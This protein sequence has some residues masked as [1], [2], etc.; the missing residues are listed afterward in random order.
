M[1][2]HEHRHVDADRFGGIGWV[3]RTNGV[4]TN[5]EKWR[6]ARA[7]MRGQG[8][9]LSSRLKL[10]ANRRPDGVMDIP[11]PPDSAMARDAEDAA[12]YQSAELLGHA[13]RTWVYGRALAAADG[14]KV[15][16]ELFYVAC[17]LHDLGLIETVTGEDFT[18]RG[19]RAAGKIV[20]RFRGP[21]GALIVKDAIAAHSTPGITVAND[22]PEPFYV[23]AGATCDLG[24]VR[25]N[26]LTPDLVEATMAR[27]PRNGL[28][29][30]IT[31]RIK[32]EGDAVPGGRFDLLCAMGFTLAIRFAPSSF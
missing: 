12:S 4:L 19:A 29:T 13:R 9:A 2:G 21:D 31:P 32:A 24:G 27:H 14:V 15:D 17:L 20:E 6:L 8:Q 28:V 3:E 5:A 26:D 23:Q 16:E 25:L 30:D 7:V 22:G 11:V 10:Y 1:S 18:L